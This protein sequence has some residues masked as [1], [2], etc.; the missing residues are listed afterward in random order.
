[1]GDR[2]ENL[3]ARLLAPWFDVHE[4]PP[5][6]LFH[7]TTVEGLLGILHD[8]SIWATHSAYLNDPSEITHAHSFIQ[9]ILEKKAEAEEHPVAKELLFRARYAINPADGMYQYFV[10]SF[11]EDADLLSQWRGYSNRGG[12]YALGFDSKVIKE[13]ADPSP[14]LTLRRVVYDHDQQRELINTTIDA[15][16]AE[17]KDVM[18]PAD[19]AKTADRIIPY[20]VM[21]LRDHFSEY[22]FSFKNLAFREEKEWRLIVQT[23]SGARERVLKDLQFRASGGI[24]VPYLP[25]GLMHDP[26]E[27]GGRLPVTT[28]VYGPTV[29]SQRA[30][31]SLRD[32]LDKYGYTSVSIASSQVPLRP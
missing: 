23:N 31:H 9:Q 19:D 20:F 15:A 16:L 27:R 6:H 21:F 10:I 18:E 28:V 4:E 26:T 1:M 8:H 32:A 22:H 3:S 17:L 25:V 14:A 7:Y 11:C 12:G 30:K 2:L 13:L 29:D 5:T 24:A